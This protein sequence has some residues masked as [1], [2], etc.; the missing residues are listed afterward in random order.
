MI[1]DVFSVPWA[2]AKK[3]GQTA[4]RLF[5]EVLEFDEVDVYTNL[6]KQQVTE[7]LSKLE[8]KAD[9]FEEEKSKGERSGAFAVGIVWIGHTIN[10]DIDKHNEILKRLGVTKPSHDYV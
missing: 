3:R 7:Q 10:T 4:E 6:A 8:E 9:I 1:S 2:N 5:K